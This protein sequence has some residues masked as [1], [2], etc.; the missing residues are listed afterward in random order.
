MGEYRSEFTSFL[1]D[2]VREHVGLR[3]LTWKEVPKEVKA[4][5][6]DQA[7]HFFDIE[8]CRRKFVMTRLGGLLRNFRRKMYAGFIQ[9][10][11]K[12]PAKLAKVPRQ[13]STLVEQADWDRF[14]AHTQTDK[15]KDVSK[16]TK[17]ARSRSVFDHRLGRGG[18]PRL[19]EKLVSKKEIAVDDVPTRAFMWRKGRENKDGELV[20]PKVKKMADYLMD[21]EAQIKDGIIKIGPDEDA[22]TVVFGREQGSYLRGVGCGVTPSTYWHCPR[23]RTIGKDKIKIL[24]LQLENEKL[25]REKKDEELKNLSLQIEATNN[26]LNKVMA[27]LDSQGLL[28]ATKLDGTPISGNGS[29][30]SCINVTIPASK[31]FLTPVKSVENQVTPTADTS[32]MAQKVIITRRKV[33]I[34]PRT[35]KSQEKVITSGTRKKICLSQPSTI[36]GQMPSQSNQTSTIVQSAMKC[37]LYTLNLNNPV[38]RGTAFLSDQQGQTIHG[39]PLQ[40]DCYRVSVD[41]VVKGAAFLPY[42]A[43]DM[44]TVEDALGSFVAWPKNHI[45]IIDHQEKVITSGTRKKICLSQPSTISGRMPSQSNQTSTI[46]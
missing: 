19:K 25:L 30:D 33:Y 34:S 42:E 21:I 1:G 3:W 16:T 24:E 2:T 45:K 31:E 41:E 38:A 22:L 5:L 27:Q 36:S 14:V 35:T 29:R 18:Y 46:V 43:D 6:W 20:A 32:I 13:Y 44:R 4:K 9:P 10:N 40:D 17:I 37:T 7:T 28:S 11:L 39:V 23:Q 12:K 15:F 26:K 8:F